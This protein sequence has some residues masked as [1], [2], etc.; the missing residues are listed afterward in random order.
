ML[1][2]YCGLR[3]YMVNLS[4]RSISLLDESARIPIGADEGSVL[5][6]VARYAGVK[7]TLPPPGPV[8]DCV[9]KAECEYQNAHRPDYQYSIALSPFSV[10]SFPKTQ[11]GGVRHFLSVLMVGTPSA[12]RD[13]FSLRDWLV[14][15]EVSIRARR[16][17]AVDSYLYVEGRNRWLGNTWRLSAEMPSRDMRSRAYAIDG[18]FL[19]FPGNGGAGTVQYLT[20][21]A[22]PEQFKSAQSFN[23]RCIMALVPCRCLSDL[24]PLSFQYL[25]RHPDVGS[26]IETDD[27][28]Y[29]LNP[30]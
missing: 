28:A 23:T 27:C 22:T 4:H 19:T 24:T 16:V 1:L 21:A 9:D 30:H 12:W 10:M 25:S 11:T 5:P 7:W 13:P 6:L 17:V 26:S 3:L 15:V 29:R 14:D 2:I 20:P 18:T 8:E